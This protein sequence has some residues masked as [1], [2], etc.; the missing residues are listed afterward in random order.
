MS[1]TGDLEH[2]PIVDVMQLLHQTRKSG[3][4]RVKGR[5]GESQLVF[6]D[7]YMVSANHLNN[8][9]RIGKILVDL[10][11][12]TP[13]IL[14]QALKKQG[15]SGADR[16]P[17]IVTLIDQGLVKEEDAY[18]GL[19]HLIEL[20]VVEILTWKKGTFTLEVMPTD[21]V[22]EYRFY[23]GKLTQEINVDTQSVLMDAL[24]IFDEKMRD[25]ELTEEELTEDDAS[26]ADPGAEDTL[27]LSADDLG[28]ADLDQLER[29]IPDVFTGLADYDPAT[30]HRLKIEEAAPDLSMA[31][32]EELVAFLANFFAPAPTSE[33]PPRGGQAQAVLFF[34]NDELVTH[35]VTTACKHAGIPVF[36]T[37][38]EQDLAP[39]VAQSLTYNSLPILVFDAPEVAGGR[40]SAAK[41][42]TLRQQLREKEPRI[43][44]IQLVSPH[45][46]VF[47]LRAYGD[48]VRAV[49]PRPSQDDCGETFAADM[50]RFLQ[51]LRTYVEG[52][53]AEQRDNPLE[54]LKTGL[55]RLHHLNEAPDIAL[56][57]L[58]CVAGMFERSLT[59]IVRGDE[60][61]AERGIG[62]GSGTGGEVTPP[63]GFR[64]PLAQASLLRKVVEAGELYYGKSDDAVVRE[65]LFAAIGTPSRTNI[66]LLPMRSRGKTLSLIYGDFGSKE[67]SP[68]VSDQLE[69]LASQAELVLENALYRKSLKNLS[70]KC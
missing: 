14:D 6:K 1:F 63:L 9:I 41:L 39:I 49:L 32:R 47:A 28:L 44:I 52:I 38:E 62:I 34:S 48:G 64:I 31:D 40:F 19:E 61:I 46:Y 30:I 69:I 8:S 70:G 33:V 25:G 53:V 29:K 36:A 22:D 20:A 2:L 10:N 42:A 5:K 4:L 21:A 3:I 23:P 67:I 59:L 24:R 7:G 16:K 55:N 57:L 66:L 56:V 26:P 11:I 50:V 51:T 35:F 13:E 68:V 65:H 60:L 17:L 54:R 15:E 43:C 45:D 37:N 58:E 27:L 18:K 12:I